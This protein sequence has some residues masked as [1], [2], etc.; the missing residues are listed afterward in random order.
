MTNSNE[1][2][3]LPEASS[4]E[5]VLHDALSA[6]GYSQETTDTA[7]VLVSEFKTGEILPRTIIDIADRYEG[8]VARA[9]Q[10]LDI[11]S[12][13]LTTELPT[14]GHL[15]ED[16]AE[17]VDTLIDM[18]EG[19]ELSHV[20]IARVAEI[21][22]VNVEYGGRRALGVLEQ[23]LS[24]L[25]EEDIEILRTDESEALLVE[26]QL[27]K[28]LQSD[29]FGYDTANDPSNT[30]DVPAM[31][32]IKTEDTDTIS[33]RLMLVIDSIEVI[34]GEYELLGLDLERAAEF[35]DIKLDSEDDFAL[36]HERLFNL[37]DVE[38]E[39][40]KF[41]TDAEFTQLDEKIDYEKIVAEL[42]M[43]R[44]VIEEIPD[45]DYEEPAN[46]TTT[47]VDESGEEFEI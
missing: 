21:L 23:L 24:D 38:L 11:V 25:S 20:S 7:L 17:L 22:G 37:T 42:I 16:E 30:G 41:K 13:T 34:L 9:K 6:G 32:E 29:E 45:E 44:A 26:E 35:L 47:V 46:E 33:P 18:L 39:E 15:D 1:Q 31:S 12:S 36:L 5:L 4:A 28:Y 2:P 27:E 3:T 8:D 19:L 10:A 14:D 40:L 43:R